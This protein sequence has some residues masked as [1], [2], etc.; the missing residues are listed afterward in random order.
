MMK[1][2]L[3]YSQLS[4]GRTPLGMEKVSSYGRC[5]AMGVKMYGFCVAG[6]MD[7]CPLTGGVH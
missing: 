3:Q 5:P 4:S 1:L 7:W 6:T 2:K